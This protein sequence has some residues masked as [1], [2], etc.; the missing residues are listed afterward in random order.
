MTTDKTKVIDRKKVLKDLIVAFLMPTL[1]GK[2]LILYFGL[3][4]SNYPGEGYGY[5]LIATVIFTLAM[6]GRLIWKY[7]NVEDL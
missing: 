3:Q 2:S 5:G 6:A 7:R 1:I 4:Y